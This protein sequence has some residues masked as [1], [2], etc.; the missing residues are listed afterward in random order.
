MTILDGIGKLFDF[1]GDHP[2]VAAL[3]VTGIA[4]MASPD[5]LDVLEK[6]EELRRKRE[7]EDLKRQ[8][9]NKKVGDIRL[10]KSDASKEFMEQSGI[11]TSPMGIINQRMRGTV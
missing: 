10:G 3:G 7:T 1:L 6:K 8:N 5:E 2:F 9:A 4:G 11:S